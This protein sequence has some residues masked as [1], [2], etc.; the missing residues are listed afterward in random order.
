MHRYLIPV[1]VYFSNIYELIK[2]REI[3]CNIIKLILLH[4]IC[5]TFATQV[6]ILHVAFLL[7]S[8]LKKGDFKFMMMIQIFCPLGGLL[9]GDMIE[10]QIFLK[11]LQKVIQEI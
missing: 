2:L 9:I 8:K 3:D 5:D 6:Q 4:T 7:Q 1:V 11:Y 10:L